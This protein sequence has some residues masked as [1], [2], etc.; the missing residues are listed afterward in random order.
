[1][2]RKKVPVSTEYP[3]HIT[4]RCIDREW[5]RV[6][7]PNAWNIFTDYLAFI[8]RGFNV[9]I[10]SFVMMTNHFHL[11]ASFPSRNLPAAMNYFMRETSRCISSDSNRINQVYGAPHFKC[12]IHNYH[13]YLHAYKYVY[14]NPVEAGLCKRVEDYAFSS[15]SGL[16]G[17]S[18]LQFPVEN[19]LILFPDF[20]PTIKWLNE[21]YKKNYKDWIGRALRH[22]EFTLPNP[23]FGSEN[24]LE[25]DLS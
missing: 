20:E 24:P 14:R 21:G 3:Y 13:Y 15:L 1:M 10:H 12:L 23:R 11:L 8:N 7:I 9:K 19:D 2:A 4:A 22:S 18:T 25:L 6:G 5:F 16:V 17:L